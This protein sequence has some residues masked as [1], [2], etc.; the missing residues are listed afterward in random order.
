MLQAIHGAA[1]AA[2]RHPGAYVERVAVGNTVTVKQIEQSRAEQKRT[3]S[4]IVLCAVF[5]C[6]GYRDGGGF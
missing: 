1:A 2:T 3:V 5:G 6:A 4:M